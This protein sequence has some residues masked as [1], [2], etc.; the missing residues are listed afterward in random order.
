M[1]LGPLSGSSPTPNDGSDNERQ[2]RLP[3]A[4]STYS[5]RSPGIS[6]ALSSTQPRPRQ[7]VSRSLPPGICRAHSTMPLLCSMQTTQVRA[8]DSVATNRCLLLAPMR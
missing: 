2:S 4:A 7:R 3:S 1:L 6:T 5:S 8:S